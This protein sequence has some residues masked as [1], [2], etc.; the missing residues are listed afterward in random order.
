MFSSSGL[1]YCA[2]HI[3][4]A[5][6]APSW[7]GLGACPHRKFFQNRCSEVESGSIFVAVAKIGVEVVFL[8]FYIAKRHAEGI[9]GAQGKSKM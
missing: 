5:M 8:S 7:G 1:A 4:Y 2:S 3:E 9:H 6:P